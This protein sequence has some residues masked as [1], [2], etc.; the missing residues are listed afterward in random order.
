MDQT[1]RENGIDPS[2]RSLP[3][4]SAMYN[5]LVDQVTPTPTAPIPSILTSELTT[6][7]P[8]DSGDVLDPS[9]DGELS[10]NQ[11]TMSNIADRYI[12]SHRTSC[13]HMSCFCTASDRST[14]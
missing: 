7:Q 14:H 10:S 3:I 1:L 6:L 11:D 9:K 4:A 5:Q 8:S 13:Q 12:L 2:S